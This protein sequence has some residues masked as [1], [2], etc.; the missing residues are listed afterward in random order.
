MASLHG[1][2]AQPRRTA[3]SH[4]LFGTAKLAATKKVPRTAAKKATGEEKESL[5]GQSAS[6][7]LVGLDGNPTLLAVELRDEKRHRTLTVALRCR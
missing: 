5:V 6:R 3:S 2:V 1:L 7:C 4:G